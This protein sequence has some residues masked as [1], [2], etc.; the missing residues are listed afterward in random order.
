MLIDQVDGNVYGGEHLRNRV[1]MRSATEGNCAYFVVFEKL[2]HAIDQ[3]VEPFDPDD[4]RRARRLF[5]DGKAR[6]LRAG[7]DSEYRLTHTYTFVSWM[8]IG[9][10]LTCG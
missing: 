1:R 10:P 7:I 2:A 3:I 8:T 5:D 4:Q 9:I 6:F